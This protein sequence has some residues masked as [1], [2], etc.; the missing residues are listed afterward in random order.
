VTIPAQTSPPHRRDAAAARV[1]L[2]LA[3]GFPS[4]D[5]RVVPSAVLEEA[6]ANL[7]VDRASTPDAL[8][9]LLG[10]PDTRVLL[11]PYGSAFPLA[12]W[13]A[14][15]RFLRHGG[16]LVVLG[17][18]PFHQPVRQHPER[19]ASWVLSPRQPTYAREL[20]I[21][22]AELWQRGD[23]P[24]ATRV[25]PGTG[26]DERFPEAMRTWQLTL[27]LATG[28][29]TPDDDGTAGPRDALVRPLVHVVDEAGLARGCPLLEIDRLRGD[30]AGARWV[31]APCDA[32]LD[33]RLI[34][35]LVR[36]ALSGAAELY[37]VPVQASVEPGQGA[38]LRVTRRRPRPAA[39]EAP[40][41][42]ARVVVSDDAGEPVFTGSI[43]LAGSA[44]TST[45]L[46][47]VPASASSRPGLYHARV[48]LPEGCAEPRCIDTGFWVR[49]ERLLASAPRL[50]VS[51]DWLR[52]DGAVFPIVGTTYM[53]SDVHRKF[54][55]EPNPHVWDRDFAE[56]TR[57]GVNFVRT[58]LWTAWGRLM[59][60]PGAIDEAALL[61]LDAFVQTAAKHG[62]LVCFNFFA[63]LPPTYSGDNPYLDPRALEGQRELLT[64]FASRYAGVGWVHWDLINEP[65]YAPRA[66]LWKTRA[67]GDGHE[68]RAFEA[69]VRARHG[70][71]PLL[72]AERWRDTIVGEAALGTP[73]LDAEFG[74]LVIREGRRPRKVRDFREYTQ[75]VVAG[76]AK[77]LRD[78][79][80]AAGRDPLVTLGQDEG[81]TGDRPM[82]QVLG[83]VLD[84]T[85]VHTWWNN[86]DLLWDGVVTKLPER[87]SVHQE[88]GLM[89]LEDLDGAP[90]RSPEMAARVLE[91]KFAYA[92][93]ARG[94][95]VI[96]WAW[97]INPYQPIDN[98][99][100]IGLIRPDGTAK[101]ELAALSE[102]A[103][104][105]AQAAPW[106]DD[107]E[108]DPVVLLVPH[109]R[110]FLG[111]PHGIDAT[112][113]VVRVLGERFGVVPTAI[114]DLRVREQ[115][116]VGRRLVIV[117]TPEVLDERAAS[118]LLSAARSGTKVLVTG[119]ID[120]DSYREVPPSLQA[121]GLVQPSRALAMHERSRWSPE[122]PLAFE[123]LMTENMRRSDG[124]ELSSFEGNVWHEPLPLELARQREPLTRLL[125]AALRSAGV[126]TQPSRVPVAARV[127]RAPRAAL[128][129]CVN[130]TAE[131]VRRRVAVDGLALDI[132]VRAFGARLALI[133][134]GSG[135][136]LCSTPGAAI[137]RD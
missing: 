58:G 102:C 35:A 108:P 43:A 132:P 28:K 127:L 56:M 130:E 12:A 136:V 76:W 6:L 91:R 75:D 53:A 118:A 34:A 113:V 89:R 47:A 121:L 122:E 72:V 9:A 17:G 119:A 26:L 27:R 1:A 13:P 49:D 59:L 110:L 112:K 115:Q 50:G 25:L 29:D 77:Q 40:S 105:F 38:R 87:P 36:R 10:E 7:P 64:L 81:G 73:P 133:E 46:L 23:A 84:Y 24:H 137:D 19:G 128:V 96:E 33:A 80:R 90:W 4:V 103:A 126:A 20:L 42:H 21:G 8:A 55:F 116:L 70:G 45:G 92:F 79:L 88:T 135:R 131:D 31:L 124:P 54:L 83:E 2:F 107:F 62:V 44:E 18:A 52:K 100:V 51:R 65:S 82:Q 67:I 57:R 114:S 11:L 94:A 120:G 109:A 14:I 134:A 74:H 48:E 30:D 61:A 3:P 86:D 68:R 104:F 101:P 5:A 60:D 97:N 39:G 123:G 99:S 95:G 117:A 41:L 66:Q 98:E 71:D 15:A 32:E 78:V 106:L 85:A 16:S 129:V 111:R 37:A 22:P 69:W 93:A 125:E 63:F